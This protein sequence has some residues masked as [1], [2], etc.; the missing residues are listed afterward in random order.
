M[1]RDTE[2]CD[3]LFPYLSITEENEVVVHCMQETPS[4]EAEMSL[5]HANGNYLQAAAGLHATPGY[6]LPQVSTRCQQYRCL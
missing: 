5:V 3:Y 6:E 2:P 4:C 1:S